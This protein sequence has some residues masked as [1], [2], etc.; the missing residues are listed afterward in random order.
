[1]EGLMVRK[2]FLNSDVRLLTVMIQHPTKDGIIN[3]ISESKKNG[4]EAFG[5][6]LE[7]LN[8]QYRN[9]KDYL[10]I[11]NSTG[12]LPIYVTNYRIGSNE[13]KSDEQLALELLDISAM[14]YLLI[15]VMGDYF[16]EKNEYELTMNEL[17]VEKQ[18]KLIEEIHKN[19][20]QVIMSSH[21]CK[22][23]PLDKVLE[24]AFEQKRRGA[25]IIK[26]VTGASNMEEQLENLRI[27]NVLKERLG[28]PFLFL[29][30]GECSIHRRLGVKLGCCMSLCVYMRNEWSYS[31][32][33]L[34]VD[35]KKI[36]DDLGF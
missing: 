23:I 13:G 11:F 5:L 9:H 8:S 2:T 29:S 21:V 36:R 18:M 26:I 27:T 1:M 28:K 16:G 14:D 34:L 10:D 3:A 33:P 17:A 12:E 24:I 20:S 15:D 25:D 30:N 35:Q 7:I 31:L 19:G 6:Q 4:A 22:F 32:Q